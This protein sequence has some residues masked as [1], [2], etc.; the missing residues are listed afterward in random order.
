MLK[1]IDMTE[2]FNYFAQKKCINHQKRKVS[3]V[4]LHEDCW[5]SESDQVFFCEDCNVNHIKQHGNSLRFDAL[6]TNELFEELDEFSKNQNTTDKSK[7][8]INNFELKINELQ[9]KIVNWTTHQFARLKRSFESY[10][11]EKDYCEPINNL[12]KMLSEAQIELSFNYESIEKIKNYCTQTKKLQNELNEVIND[13]IINERRKDFDIIDE[14]FN[15]KLDNM[16]NEIQENVE[17]QVKQLTE[18]LIDCNQNS[19]SL[20]NESITV[21]VSI[22]KIEIARNTKILATNMPIVMLI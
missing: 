18:Y 7:E 10:L 22:P 21:E 9:R 14:E 8:R 17:N 12:K 4:C 19:Q 5:N 13:Q 16:V 6:F 1:K 2:V 3:S 11:V 20:S 15:L